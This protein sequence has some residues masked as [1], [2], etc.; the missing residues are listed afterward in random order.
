M[1]RVL[2]RTVPCTTIFRLKEGHDDDFRVGIHKSS[3]S[4]MN[5]LKSVKPKVRVSMS[6]LSFRLLYYGFVSISK[7]KLTLV[8]LNFIK[9]NMCT[10][11]GGSMISGTSTTSITKMTLLR[12]N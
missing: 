4:I 7:Q 1:R 11:E 6:L 3:D 5:C 2:F 9:N 10:K 8:R 12:G